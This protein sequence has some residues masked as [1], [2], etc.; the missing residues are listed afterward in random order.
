MMLLVPQNTEIYNRMD[1][2]GCNFVFIYF[3]SLLVKLGI[4]VH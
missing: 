2:V 1:G 3:K 4:A